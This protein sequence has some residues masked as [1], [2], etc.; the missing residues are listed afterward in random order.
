MHK[1]FFLTFSPQL[2][3]AVLKIL[4]VWTSLES[5]PTPDDLTLPSDPNQCHHPQ[6]T[7]LS[8]LHQHKPKTLWVWCFFF[9]PFDKKIPPELLLPNDVNA[10]F[11]S[12]LYRVSRT[13]GLLVFDRDETAGII[14]AVTALLGVKEE[15]RC[16][17]FNTNQTALVL[18]H[19]RLRR[20]SWVEN[21]LQTSQP[22]N[23]HTFKNGI[24]NHFSPSC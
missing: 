15:S 9:L 8:Q 6:F 13:L 16:S 4:L 24:F 14:L 7:N 12:W 17:T 3:A 21:G 22:K 20:G 1:R 11:P 18:V 19:S 2:Y 10:Y 23:F 5:R